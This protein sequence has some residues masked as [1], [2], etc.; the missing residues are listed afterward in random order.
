MTNPIELLFLMS[1]VSDKLFIWTH[2]FDGL[3]L[4][5][6]ANLSPKFTGH[7]ASEY[8]GFRHTLYRQEYAA[9]LEQAGFCGGSTS[10]SYWLSREEILSCLKFLGYSKVQISFEQ[11]DHPHGPCFALVATRN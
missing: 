2:Y 5:G 10:F 4:H 6:Q 3:I 8:S 9:S 11:P 1:K 7:T